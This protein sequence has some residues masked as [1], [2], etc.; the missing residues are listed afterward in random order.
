MFS[1]CNLY[2]ISCT[3]KSYL[4]SLAQVLWTLSAIS[5]RDGNL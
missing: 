2:A 1:I 4:S 3:H 5:V